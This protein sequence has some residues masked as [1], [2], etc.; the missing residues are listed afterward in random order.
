MSSTS[1]PSVSSSLGQPHPMF[2][3]PDIH[4]SSLSQET[5]CSFFLLRVSLLRLRGE[6]GLSMAPPFG[7]SPVQHLAQEL[8]GPILEDLRPTLSPPMLPRPG[9]AICQKNKWP[10]LPLPLKPLDIVHKFY[11]NSSR[12]SESKVV[13]DVKQNHALP[14]GFLLTKDVGEIEKLRLENDRMCMENEQLQAQ[15][16]KNGKTVLDRHNNLITL[17]RS[18]SPLVMSSPSVAVQSP[19]IAPN[20]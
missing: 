7:G 14:Y 20:P 2:V 1:A 6:L 3:S 5:P 19:P 8:V 9:F 12:T 13:T 15:L 10:D 18:L 11:G 4:K 16:V 17:V